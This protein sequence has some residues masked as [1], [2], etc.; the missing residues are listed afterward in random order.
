MTLVEVPQPQLTRDY[1]CSNAKLSERLGFIPSRSVVEAV[2]DLLR[3]I[4]VEDRAALTDPRHYNIR[5]LE[6]MH[7]VSPRIE[8]FGAVL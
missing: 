7:E 4:D 2:A 5:W 8:R 1:E 3:R 6:L